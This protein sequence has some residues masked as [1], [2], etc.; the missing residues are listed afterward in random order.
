MKRILVLY[1]TQSGQL[2]QIIDSVL[3]SL[4]DHNKYKIDYECLNPDP[5]YPFPWG[6]QFF[7]CFPESVKGIP[8]NL[9]SF[10]FNS[11]TD[12]DLIILGYQPW[13]LSPSIPIWSFLNSKKAETILKDKKVITIIGA[14]N[15][16]ICSQ[17]IIARRLMDLKANLIGNIVLTD[18]SSNYISAFNIIRWLIKGNK[19]PTLLLPEAG[20]S[21]KYISNA[22][23]FGSIIHETL[24]K[25]DWENLQTR[26]INNKALSVKYHLLKIEKNARKIFDKFASYILK[27]GQA[28]DPERKMRILAFKYYL[29]FMIF[30]VSP[31]ASLVFMILRIIFYRRINK[32]I[33]YYSGISFK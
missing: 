2:K 15:M 30:V 11:E 12:Y 5:D 26:L 21:K 33:L 9:K 7:D 20:V 19:N 4:V 8:C 18:H 16:W 23:V 6:K 27:K 17:E 22:S 25:N 32:I 29:L 31:F 24:L 14:R 28:G 13:Y 3:S 1:Y 10:K